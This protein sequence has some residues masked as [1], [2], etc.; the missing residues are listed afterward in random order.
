MQ[1]QSRQHMALELDRFAALHV[2]LVKLLKL[3]SGAL[4]FPVNI[5]RHEK[6]P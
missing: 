2:A 1:R 4:R 5:A 3:S 6:T